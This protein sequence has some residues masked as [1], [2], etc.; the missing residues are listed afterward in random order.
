MGREKKRDGIP[1]NLFH[2]L[3][4]LVGRDLIS[5]LKVFNS[6]DFKSFD[7]CFEIEMIRQT[8]TDR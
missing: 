5:Y 6:W 3:P 4:G 7:F 2:S 1:I 8:V